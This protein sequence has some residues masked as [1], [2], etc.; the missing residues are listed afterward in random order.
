MKLPHLN[1]LERWALRLLH[2]SPRLALVIVKPIDTSLVSWSALDDD[3]LA[4]A[5]AQELLHMPDDDEPLSMQLE[6][7]FHQPAYGE[8]E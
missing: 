4:V 5:M 7:I 2:R 3:E 6:R 1:W 8:R